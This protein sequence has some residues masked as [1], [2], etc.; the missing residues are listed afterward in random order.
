V[1]PYKLAEDGSSIV[2]E[3]NN[4]LQMD[5]LEEIKSDLIHYLRNKLQN[6]NIIVTPKVSKE[7]G[8]KML[9]TNK[10]KL[11]HLA[12]KNPLVNE[13]QK[14]LGLDPDY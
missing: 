9:Y 6:D 14:K 1:Q 8:K 12:E 7:N 11:D 3:L 13:L 2:I 10:E 4:S 5:I